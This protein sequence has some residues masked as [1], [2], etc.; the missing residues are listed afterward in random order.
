MGNA[1]IAGIDRSIVVGTA[2]PENRQFH[3]NEGRVNT[4]E[5]GIIEQC[6]FF[7]RQCL[8]DG[9]GVSG[10]SQIA[11]LVDDFDAVHVDDTAFGYGAV[12]DH[13]AFVV[14]RD[15]IGHD[16]GQVPPHGVFGQERMPDAQSGFVALGE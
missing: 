1:L 3:P 15:S 2:E 6:R 11:V 16:F 13:A 9:F 8:T 5:G 7:T 4:E 14:Y 12:R 10:G